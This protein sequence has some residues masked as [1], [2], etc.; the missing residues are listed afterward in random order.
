MFKKMLMN[1]L[2]PML[3]DT[4]TS[5]LQSL[6]MKTSNTVDDKLVA[7]VIAERE[8]IIAEIKASL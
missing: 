6:A 2:M 7:T 1:W 5:A 3:L 4:L 8:N